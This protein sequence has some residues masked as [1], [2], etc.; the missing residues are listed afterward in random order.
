MG[1][2]SEMDDSISCIAEA[3]DECDDCPSL[4]DDEQAEIMNCSSC[5]QGCFPGRGIEKTS[6]L[7]QTMLPLPK[8]IQLLQ[9]EF[10]KQ[11]SEFLCSFS[12]M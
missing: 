3:H 5:L 11:Q 4:S 2:E 9:T 10:S 6:R 8:A 7:T 1:S 12:N